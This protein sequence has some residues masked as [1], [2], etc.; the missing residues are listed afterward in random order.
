MGP[1][2]G[3]IV[4]NECKPPQISDI[5][6]SRWTVYTAYGTLEPASVAVEEEVVRFRKLGA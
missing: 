1:L 3:K 2:F 5:F 4:T 6:R